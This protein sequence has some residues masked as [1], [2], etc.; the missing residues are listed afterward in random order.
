MG[1]RRGRSGTQLE[2]RE[3]ER[4]EV[5]E[6]EV[7]EGKESGFFACY[8]L[9]SLSP[10]H[11]RRTYIGFT[12]NPRRR[13]RQHNG[14]IRCGAWR[15][16]QGRPW[17]MILC[18]YG[19]PSN[20]SALQFEWAWQHPKESLA[21]RKAAS[22]FKS[23]SGVANK[24]KLAY[25][26]LSLPAWENLNLTVNFFSTKYMKHTSG[27]PG[28][29]KQMNAVICVMDELPCYVK[30]QILDV[31]NEEDE[32]ENNNEDANP[33]ASSDISIYHVEG[34][35]SNVQTSSKHLFDWKDADDF[36]RSVELEDS[37]CAVLQSPKLT[38]EYCRKASCNSSTN[39]LDVSVNH[40][41]EDFYNVGKASFD[42]LFHWKESDNSR[43]SMEAMSYCLSESPQPILER[44]KTS[45]SRTPRSCG[46]DPIGCL[47]GNDLDESRQPST[48]QRSNNKASLDSQSLSP[49]GDVIN[50][51]TPSSYLIHFRTKRTLVYPEIIDLTDSPVIIQL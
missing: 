43:R 10:R 12:V 27:C 46:R 32:P 44:S 11:K 31:N 49:E 21:V 13:I 41:V 2:A 4:R 50:L 18:I 30:G 42:D 8:L 34:D 37:L 19:F 40:E 3:I 16:K 38:K 5:G 20:V 14:E 23:L 22:N 25:T 26:M 17:E 33:S 15:T 24:I 35:A 7:D 47:Q 6:E 9:C 48:P 39:M 28:L 36:R 1:R 51:V 45:S 29:P